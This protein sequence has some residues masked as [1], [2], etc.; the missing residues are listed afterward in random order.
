MSNTKDKG[1]DTGSAV[2]DTMED[3]QVLQ[4][5]VFNERIVKHDALGKLRLR[6][7]TLAIQRKIEA[8][9]RG[10][11]KVLLS[12]KDTVDGKSVPAYKSKQVMMKEYIEA[13]WWS[14]EKEQERTDLLQRQISLVA[15]LEIL[16][17][18]SEE[19]LI[20]ELHVIRDQLLSGFGDDASGELMEVVEEVCSPGGEMTMEN[21][22][23]LL[24][25]STS[26]DVDDAIDALALYQ[27]MYESYI[28]LLSITTKVAEI[29]TEYSNLFADSWQEQLQYFQRL[30]QLYH[31]ITKADTDEH[32]WETPFDIETETS[33]ADIRWL[34]N[35]LNDFLQGITEDVQER[36]RKYDFF[37]QWT[38][39]RSSTEEL[40]VE[41]MSK[42]DGEEPEKMPETSSEVTVTTVPSPTTDTSTLSTGSDSIDG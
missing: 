25:N 30:C 9:V 2:E 11:K 13:G 37:G 32:L 1:A 23:L 40:P 5:A 38:G 24:A 31:C 19:S 33:V 7:P 29:E 27:R 26:T 10:Y 34:F 22:K 35:E 6:M 8:D 39:E 42:S 28:D 36:R 12:T 41:E 20:D 17:F 3:S 15:E 16:G 18:E 4:E 14:L 21:R